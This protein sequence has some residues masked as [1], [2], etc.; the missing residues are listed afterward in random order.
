MKAAAKDALEAMRRA[1][2]SDHD[3]AVDLFRWL[4]AAA[5]P[6]NGYPAYEGVP[7]GV[8][9][10]LPDDAVRGAA[11]AE[12]G[13][14]ARVA[15]AARFFASSDIVSFRKRALREIPDAFF[16]RARPLVDPSDADALARLDHARSVAQSARDARDH[17]APFEIDGGCTVIGQS[18]GG[19]LSA[20]VA[21]DAGAIVS[22]DAETIVRF[23]PG[24][25]QPSVV[26]V[27]SEHFI[28][29]AGG[30]RLVWATMNDGDV[31]ARDGDGPIERI[32]SGQRVPLAIVTAG[33][34]VAWLA[35]EGPQILTA[36]EEGAPRVLVTD[37]NLSELAADDERV[38]Y[39]SASLTADCTLRSV[40]W[41]GGRSHS[42]CDLPWLGASM[43]SPRVV[44]SEGEVLVAIAAEVRAIDA[45]TGR[46]RTLVSADAPVAAI[47]ATPRVVAMVLGRDEDGERW[48]LAVAPREGGAV[49]RLGS[50]SRATY[51][52]HALVIAG[53]W[54][55]TTAGDRILAARID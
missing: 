51:H 3:I 22:T 2:A 16:T 41:S 36:T 25:T 45:K 6:W 42:L 19:S 1:G 43:G 47:A 21:L 10:A 18:E 44:A 17:S 4:N 48:C 53:P 5:G 26:A 9:G 31:F 32:A 39:T 23:D 13:D 46:A 12:D 20:L 35:R 38:Y 52:R 28:V 24:S 11:L 37:K 34:R 54:A 15:A 49:R 8:L 55:C 14:D 30:P 33:D 40:S 50:F 29:L 27:A 7:L